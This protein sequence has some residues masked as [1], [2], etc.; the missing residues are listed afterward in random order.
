MK[1]IEK[2]IGCI[3]QRVKEKGEVE[4][5]KMNTMQKKIHT[6]SIEKKIEICTKLNTNSMSIKVFQI[7]KF[8]KDLYF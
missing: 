6:F 7:Q 3:E 4:K 2:E 8:A 1:E 5:D